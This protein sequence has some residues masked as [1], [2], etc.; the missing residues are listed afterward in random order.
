MIYVKVE[1][2]LTH[3]K[4]PDVYQLSRVPVE[5]EVL[6]DG[7]ES[8]VVKRVCHIANPDDVQ[9]VAMVRVT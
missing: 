4:K 9:C 2:A 5:G 3:N 6:V 7:E 1:F 8:Y